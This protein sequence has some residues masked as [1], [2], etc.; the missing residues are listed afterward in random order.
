MPAKVPTLIRGVRYPSITD[1]ARALG[2]HPT[3][4]VNALKRGA[5]DRVGLNGG[6]VGRPPRPTTIRGRPYPSLRAAAAALGVH[7]ST[8][9]RAL[10]RGTSENIG[11]GRAHRT[12][13]T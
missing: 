13:H 12:N 4:I 11:L 9:D 2:V 1:A 3:A 5:E 6:R 7:P 10:E 8:V